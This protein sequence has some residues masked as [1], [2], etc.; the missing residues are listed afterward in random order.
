M[1]CFIDHPSFY[2]FAVEFVAN[3]GAHVFGYWYMLA[4]GGAQQLSIE[5]R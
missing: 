3:G 5:I 2:W 4:F 1:I